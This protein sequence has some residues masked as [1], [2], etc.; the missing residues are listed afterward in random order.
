MSV[1][2]RTR[3]AIVLSS[4]SWVLIPC[5]TMPVS[6]AATAETPPAASTE[7]PALAIA[8]VQAT[9]ESWDTSISTDG[10]ITPWHEAVVGAE[11][12]GLRVTDVSVDVGD[13]VK[14]GDVLA[15]LFQDGIQADI[16]QQNAVIQQAQAGIAQAVAGLEQSRLVVAQAEA[17]VTQAQAGVQQAQAGVEQAEAGVNQAGAGVVQAQAKMTQAT[18][19]VTQA[20][21]NIAQAGAGITQAGAGVTQA[22]AAVNQ[23]DAGIRQAYATFNEAK[24]NGDRARKLKASGAMALQQVDQ[25]LTAELTA[26]AAVDN[27]KAGLQSQQANLTAQQ[28]NVSARKSAFEAEK[29]GLV[30]QK[31]ALSAGQAEVKAQMAVVQANKSAVKAQQAAV[32]IQQAG[33]IARKAEADT[34]RSAIKVQEAMVEAQQAA[35]RVQE[36]ALMAHKIRLAQSTIIA[37]DDGVISERNA[38]LGLIAEPT[39]VLFRIIRQNRLEWRAE[40]TSQELGQ[41]REQQDAT[42]RLPTGEQVRGVVQKI[43]PVLDD[44]NRNAFV[45]VS[46]PQGSSARAGMFVQ[47]QI[48]QGST[49]ALTL[50]QSAVV[51][52]DGKSYVFAVGAD[53]RVKQQAVTVGRRLS[54]RVEILSGITE[55][56]RL[57]SSGG[58]FLNDN[59]LV[60]VSGTAPATTQGG[61]TE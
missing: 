54:D 13:V 3:L 16:A 38:A 5:L 25:Y 45:Y 35:L 20:E 14:K 4:L 43:A 33:V 2:T 49:N 30:T 11:L 53:N 15:T 18:A 19:G 52:R 32:S 26:R 27:Q 28:A 47:G 55:D 42:V 58:A 51:L 21:A 59:D 12:A 46:L 61:K 24:L 44:A 23:A 29:A 50:P 56:D 60:Q 8:V 9:R 36:A 31:A 48:S 57:V 1:S 39:T 40:V 10:I 6:A 17:A 41:I 22:Q 34:Q 37:P 7:K